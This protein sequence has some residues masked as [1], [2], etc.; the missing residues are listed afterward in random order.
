MPG[1]FMN[2]A[3]SHSYQPM[4]IY[5]NLQGLSGNYDGG[6][7]GAF[8]SATYMGQYFSDWADLMTVVNTWLS[9]NPGKIV[10]IDVE[11]DSW[12][13]MQQ[14]HSNDPSTIAACVAS[15]TNPGSPYPWVPLTGYPNTVQGAARAMLHIKDVQLAAANRARLKLAFHVS[16]AGP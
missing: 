7:L 13:Y 6:I 9:A 11:P 14:N 3:N 2:L 5:E 10:T 4:F 1:N 16:R 15:A 8:Q 12:G